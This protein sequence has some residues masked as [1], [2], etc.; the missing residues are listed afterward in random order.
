MCGHCHNKVGIQS[1]SESTMRY[2]HPSA[3]LE[4]SDDTKVITSLGLFTMELSSQVYE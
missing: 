3:R 2:V 4:T 1:I